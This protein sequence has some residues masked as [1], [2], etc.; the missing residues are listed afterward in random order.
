MTATTWLEDYQR[1]LAEIGDRAQRARA[2]LD[3]LT[4]TASSASGAVTVTV[5]PAGALQQVSFGER[6]DELSRPK[7]AE[8]V[9]DAARKAHLDAVRRS[10]EALEPL[11][12]ESEASRYLASHLPPQARED[13][14]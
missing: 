1:R 13:G 11:I 7:L 9:L 4:A 3:G 12:G 14:G 6:A 2:E 8:A 10:A 5:N